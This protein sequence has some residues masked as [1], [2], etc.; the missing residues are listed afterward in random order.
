MSHTKCSFLFESLINV[1][2][3][4]C[5]RDARVQQQRQS[6]TFDNL[7][8]P[9]ISEKP[10]TVKSLSGSDQSF[11][12]TTGSKHFFWHLSLP[13]RGIVAP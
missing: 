12:M 10:H 8:S 7:F 4:L 5:K 1:I 2:F 6:E 11:Y 9:L 3:L 13:F